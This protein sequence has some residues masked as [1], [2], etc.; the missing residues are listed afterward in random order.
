M[1]FLVCWCKNGDVNANAS[2]VGIE[3][4]SS[5]SVETDRINETKKGVVVVV[6]GENFCAIVMLKL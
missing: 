1:L 4:T 2:V 5:R 3:D 6:V